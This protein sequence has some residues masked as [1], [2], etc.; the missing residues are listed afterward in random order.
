MICHL[1]M[2]QGL[3][4]EVREQVEVWVEVAVEAGWEE[5]GLVQGRVVIVSVLI[6]T[7]VQRYPIKL[8]ALVII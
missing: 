1:V 2:E 6:R 5:I 8:V 7:V 4:E 3:S